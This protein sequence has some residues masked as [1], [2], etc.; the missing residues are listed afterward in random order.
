MPIFLSNFTTTDWIQL[1]SIIASLSISVISILVAVFTLRQNSKMIEESTR[2][3]ILIYDAYTNISSV[4]F[5][6]ILKNFGKTG[7]TITEFKSNHDMSIFDS[8][9]P[10]FEHIVGTFLAPGQ[11]IRAHIE[12]PQNIN[13]EINFD[14]KYKTSNKEYKQASSIHLAYLKNISS[15]RTKCENKDFD[16]IGQTLQDLN[17]KYL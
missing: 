16:V 15:V 14:I 13:L 3:Y 5:Y 2:P 1:F 8:K 11:S 12:L 10:P 17:E 9:Q 7:A 6:L 4:H